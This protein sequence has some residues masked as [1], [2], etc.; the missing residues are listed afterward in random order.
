MTTTE[1]P[2]TTSPQ[3]DQT[4]PDDDAVA[5]AFA[6]RMFGEALG[7]IGMFTIYL[8][9]RLGL[10]EALHDHPGITAGELAGRA[11]IASRY[12]REWLEQQTVT[13][14]VECDDRNRADDERTYRLPPGHATALLD[15]EH[16]AH[17]GALALAC[18]G[19]AGVLPDLLDAYRSGGGVPY[20]AYGADFR[21]G[22]AAFNRPGFVH[23]LAMNWL[24]ALPDLHGRLLAGEA[25]RIVDVGCGAGWSTIA[26]ATAFPNAV[27]VGFD[28]DDASIA[29]ARRNAAMA[30]VAD[31]LTFEVHD[32]ADLPEG[33]F[34]LVTIFEAVHD[35]SRPVDV[36]AEMGRLRAPG[37]HVLV[38]DERTADSFAQSE[39][40]IESFLYG[41]SVLHCLPVG[42]ADQPS[43]ATGTVMRTA[44][45]ERYAAEAGFHRVDVLPIEH[46]L[47]RFYELL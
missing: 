31:R 4:P 44:T 19:I 35:L 29:D 42:M 24:A 43:A 30:D 17:T 12:A 25:V 33:S 20:A 23:D 27:I 41:A 26:M 28:V 47:F 36:L 22:Q 45:L 10:Y 5:G 37:G 21:D 14:V 6:E 16:P 1:V 34:D 40:P 18:G 39:G 8:G 38:M 9:I 11:G 32:G 13:A 7:A 2:G 15:A 46:D 3:H